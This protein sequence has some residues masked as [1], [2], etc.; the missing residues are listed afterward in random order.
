MNKLEMRT[1]TLWVG[2]QEFPLT[3]TERNILAV[4]SDS[5][6]KTYEDIY[7]YLYNTKVKELR[8]DYRRP[9]I[10]ATCRIRKKTGLKIVTRYDYG[11]ML[12][13]TLCVY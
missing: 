11:L 1:G 8:K 5:K 3:K 12:G 10:T 2:E 13:D 7:N 9:I 4:L 6:V